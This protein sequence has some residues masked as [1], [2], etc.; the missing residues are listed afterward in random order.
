[1]AEKQGDPIK[2][3]S[4]NGIP[5]KMHQTFMTRILEILSG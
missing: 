4:E 5:E 1:M 3:L 2:L